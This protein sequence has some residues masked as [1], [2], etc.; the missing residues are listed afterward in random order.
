MSFSRVAACE[1][2][3][4]KAVTLIHLVALLLILGSCESSGSEMQISMEHYVI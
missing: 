3:C 2:E 4:V 1:G